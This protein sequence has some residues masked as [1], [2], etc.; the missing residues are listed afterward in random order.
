MNTMYKNIINTIC[1]GQHL[2]FTEIQKPKRD[3]DLVYARQL[4]MYFGKEFEVGSLEFIG[5]PFGKN[6][7]TV[8]H[9]CKVIDN[10]V[11]TDRLKREVIEK[12]RDYLNGYKTIMT[13]DKHLED[14]INSLTERLSVAEQRLINLF[15]IIDKAEKTIKEL[16]N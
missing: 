3:K 14:E 11:Y 5:E 6:Y 4:C 8:I 2:T 13:L 10:Y 1:L 12:Y 9:S 15:L 16:I 7:S